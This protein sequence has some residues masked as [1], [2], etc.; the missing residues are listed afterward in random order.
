MPLQQRVDRDLDA[1]QLA[2]VV[3]A[4]HHDA[5]AA[6]IAGT[7]ANEV[8]VLVG[9]HDEQGVGLVDAVGGEARKE[10]AECLIVAA[11]V[12]FVDRVAGAKSCVGLFVDGREIG[13]GDRDAVLLHG[14][15][16][17]EGH[18]RGRPIEARES[19]V[20][21]PVGRD[22]GDHV[23]VQVAHRET[24]ADLRSDVLV[25]EQA[26]EAE[27]PAWFGW[28]PVGYPAVR[29]GAERG[30]LRAVDRDPDEVGRGLCL[31]VVGRVRGLDRFRGAWTV[32]GRNV[33]DAL[34]FDVRRS[35]RTEVAAGTSVGH[36]RSGRIVALR[37][38][39]I[40]L[41]L[42]GP[43]EGLRQVRPVG[44]RQG[45][46]RDAIGSVE[47]EGVAH[48]LTVAI[49]VDAGQRREDIGAGVRNDRCVVVVQ[50]RAVPDQ[51][52]VQAGHLLDVRR[53]VRVVA[54]KVDVVELKL[55]DMLD[56]AS[57]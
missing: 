35:H 23:P 29:G 14:C 34:Q 52:V 56:R 38:D 21:C 6:R 7:H 17:S 41:T 27:I 54:P 2:G 11:K 43:I 1:A 9:R 48:G 4:G 24:R 46:V 20:G 25:P 37:V 55:D 31:A 5:V 10:L 3:A 53:H 51:E 13:G 22:V 30:T 40:V 16:I 8:V 12:L 26:V 19:R 15:H 36:P 33:G 45:R 28:Q 44:E 39:Q 42:S 32:D 57:S 49:R 50:D 47:H 18:G